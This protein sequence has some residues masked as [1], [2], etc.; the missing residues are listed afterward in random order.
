MPHWYVL[1]ENGEPREEPDYLKASLWFET[2]LPARRVAEDVIRGVRVST[3]FLALD[4]SHH[5]E[6]PPVLWETMIF[7]GDEDGSGS[8]YCT[9][10]QAFAGHQ[11]W[12]ERIKKATAAGQPVTLSQLLAM[13]GGEGAEQGGARFTSEGG[14]KAN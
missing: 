3:V 12:V 4:H 7:N 6:G 5:P 2:S 11:R 1:D 14:F 10:A 8:R 9:R 13:A